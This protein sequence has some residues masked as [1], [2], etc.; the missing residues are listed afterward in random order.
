MK[1]AI[2]FDCFGV[3]ALEQYGALTRAFPWTEQKVRAASAGVDL[4]VLSGAERKKRAIEILDE[5]GMDSKAAAEY[6]L[7]VRDLNKALLKDIRGLKGQFKLAILSN[8]ADDF[9]QHFRPE[10]AEELKKMFDVIVL[11]YEI[12]KAKPDAGAFEATLEKLGLDANECIFVDDKAKNVETAENLGMAGV[13]YTWGMN[14]LGALK[15][16]L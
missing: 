10:D 13:V 1:K 3:L 12:K 5:F 6:F 2:I 7:G 11:S 14:F 8:T 9:W 15:R 16:L 4:G